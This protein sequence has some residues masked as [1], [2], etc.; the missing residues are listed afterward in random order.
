MYRLAHRIS[1]LL[2]RGLSTNVSKVGGI[3][4]TNLEMADQQTGDRARTSLETADSAGL[5]ENG[6][7]ARDCKFIRK[8]VSMIFTVL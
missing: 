4:L 3:K 7:R 6:T 2:E 8:D 1:F 5:G